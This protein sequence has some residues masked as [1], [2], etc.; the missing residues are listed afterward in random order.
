M[1]LYGAEGDERSETSKSPHEKTPAGGEPARES[2]RGIIRSMVM[3]GAQPPEGCAAEAESFAR[4]V[5]L[6]FTNTLNNLIGAAEQGDTAYMN[7]IIRGKEAEGFN[8]D[9]YGTSQHGLSY[10]R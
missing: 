4:E 8:Y 9:R 7:R 6:N 2:L 3:R 1:Q 5:Q 10:E